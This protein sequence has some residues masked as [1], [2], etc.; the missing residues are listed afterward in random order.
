MNVLRHA[1]VILR[2]EFYMRCLVSVLA[3]GGFTLLFSISWQAGAGA[4]LVW[5]ATLLGSERK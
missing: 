4:L 3:I 1:L 2:A 5:W